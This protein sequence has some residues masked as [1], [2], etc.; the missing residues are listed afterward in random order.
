M[1]FVKFLLNCTA[2]LGLSNRALHRRGARIRIQNNF[3]VCI[4][5]GTSDCLE[6]RGF[7]SQEPLLIRIQNGYQRN[8]RIVQSFT[9]QVDAN[10][11]I[12]DTQAQIPN[13]F[14]ALY[15]F[16]IMMQIS[17]T[18]A[19]V[20]QIIGQ[21]F[22]HFDRQR[23]DQYALFSRCPRV[24]FSNQIINL[25]FNR[26]DKNFRGEQ[27]GRT[28]ELFHNLAGTTLFKVGWRCADVNH[29]MDALLKLRKIERPIIQRRRQAESVVNQALFSRLVA[30]VHR[31]H[32]RNRHVRL[33]NNHQKILW[34]IIHQRIRCSPRFSA[35]PHARIV[36]NA[37]AKADFF[38]HFHIIARAL[39]DALSFDKFLIFLEPCHA[40]FH[41]FA[42]FLYRCLHFVFRRDIVRCR[43]NRRVLYLTH[44]FAGQRIDFADSLNFIPEKFHTICKRVGIYR[45][46]FHGI[47]AHAEAIAFKRDVIALVLNFC[48][49]LHE[50]FI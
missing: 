21:I 11:H 15:R 7:T 22:C 40:L 31:S 37:A 33:I 5:C 20:F 28:N 8:F 3:T 12:K 10:Q 41:F 32:L 24:D 47:S 38:H 25:P 9:E 50:R 16:D 17:H 18:N 34:K 42:D 39:L 35:G 19:R 36:L 48:Q 23:C 43:I 45:P 30:R 27:S 4:S 44:A 2:A 6:H 14:H 49:P 1:F 29:L 46:D 13:D 26:P